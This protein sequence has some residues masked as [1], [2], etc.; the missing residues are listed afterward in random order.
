[1]RTATGP[2]TSVS[3]LTTAKPEPWSSDNYCLTSKVGALMESRGLWDEVTKHTL[4][5]LP[6]LHN[7][8]P[9]SPSCGPQ[10][11]SRVCTAATLTWPCRMCPPLWSLCH[12]RHERVCSSKHERHL[13]ACPQPSLTLMRGVKERT[14]VC[15]WGFLLILGVWCRNGLCSWDTSFPY[16][17]RL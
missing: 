3:L 4:H 14:S 6:L 8:Y 13:A 7:V 12:Q 10:H 15:G 2:L 1:M 16:S 11:G 17:Q 9:E 5:L